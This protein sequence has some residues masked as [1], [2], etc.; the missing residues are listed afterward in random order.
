MTGIQSYG[1]L[2]GLSV[3]F[4]FFEETGYLV[5]Y[6]IFINGLLSLLQETEAALK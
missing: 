2:E 4:H 1:I 3:P 5:P 6:D